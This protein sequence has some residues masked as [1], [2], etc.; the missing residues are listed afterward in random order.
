MAGALDPTLCAHPKGGSVVQSTGQN[1]QR[2]MLLGGLWLIYF[3]FGLV[4]AGMAPL[5]GRITTD[6]GIGNTE[7][8]L[9][10]GAWPLVYLASS[11]PC[12]VVLDRFDRKWVLFTAAVLIGLSSIARGFARDGIELFAAVAL[13]GIGGPLVSIGVPKL[14]G[15]WFTGKNRGTAIGIVMTGP[16]LGQAAALLLTD[17]VLLPLLNHSWRMVMHVEALFAFIAGAIWYGLA[18][19]FDRETT[20]VSTKSQFRLKMAI[21]LVRDGGVATVLLMGIG[22]FAINHGMNNWLPEILTEKGFA[23]ADASFWA[24]MPV[25][26]GIA[27]S[28]IMPGLARVGRRVPIIAALFAAAAMSMSLL[29]AGWAPGLALA[30]IL[31]GIVRG[32]TVAIAILLLMDAPGVPSERIGLAGG[33]FFVAAEIGGVSGAVLVGWLSDWSQSFTLPLQA[34]SIL[35]LFLFSLAVVMG[36]RLEP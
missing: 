1:P 30:L 5:I 18:S 19:R 24:A 6:L 11:I 34:F 22:I 36:R 27:A 4:V 23:P 13:F 26:V 35:G 33:L 8:G 7:M 2:W 3:S 17:Q 20:A 21:S 29:A 12:G 16:A 14:V 15:Q 25:A 9:A 31:L 28:L 10:L 32:S